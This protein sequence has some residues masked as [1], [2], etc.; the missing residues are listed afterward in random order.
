[1][2]HSSRLHLKQLPTLL[3]ILAIP[4]VCGIYFT[5]VSLNN[6]YWMRQIASVCGVLLVNNDVSCF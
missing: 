6:V 5:E 2:K 1:M 3:P 4:T